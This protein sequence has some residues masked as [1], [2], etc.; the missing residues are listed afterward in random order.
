MKNFINKRLFYLFVLTLSLTS[1]QIVT[2]TNWNTHLKDPERSNYN[3]TNDGGAN[4]FVRFWVRKIGWS[5][6]PFTVKPRSE[7]STPIIINDKIFIGS[8]AGNLL[9]YDLG[10][11]KRVL[12]IK[13]K[14]PV[15]STVTFDGVD[16]IFF[17]T[18]N[19]KVFA[20]SINDGTIK[21]SFEILS[22]AISAPLYFDGMVYVQTQSNRLY[23]LKADTGE[24][25]WVNKRMTD[26]EVYPR[27]I[28]SPAT[29]GKVIASI[30]SDG[31]LS[32]IDIKTGRDLWNIEIFEDAVS[33]DYGRKTPALIDG[34]VYYIDGGGV[35]R[36]NDLYTHDEAGKFD[37][38]VVTD[39]AIKGDIIYISGKDSFYIY[40]KSTKAIVS[41]HN[42]ICGS[43]HAMTVTS[44]KVFIIGDLDNKKW[45]DMA[46]T[47]LSLYDKDSGKLLRTKFISEKVLENPVVS[48]NIIAFL[49]ERS[50]LHVYKTLRY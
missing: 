31:T 1:C 34:N 25:W 20:A 5:Y 39:F 29:N 3:S 21:W 35:L 44:D 38:V 48:D 43:V 19:G 17:S 16:T 41:K 33:V 30:F 42:N 4:D 14:G 27:F 9:A 22:E 45:F 12:K 23:A 15:E 36:W 11:G 13:T 49:S 46:D 18:S 32:I 10:T 7:T 40:D 26:L 37:N 2:T 24:K 28:S 50:K 47:C 8:S 6:K